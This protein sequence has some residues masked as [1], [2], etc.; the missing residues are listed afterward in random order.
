M[1]STEKQ[2]LKII[3]QNQGKASVFK[4]AKEIKFSTDYC[5]LI[6]RSLIRNKIIKFSEGLYRVTGLGRKRLEELGMME[7]E[8]RRDGITLS[9]QKEVEIPTI[10]ELSVPNPE[11]IAILEQ[12]GFRTLEDVATTSAARLMELIPLK[13]AAIII[14]EAREKLRKQGKEYLWEQEYYKEPSNYD[15]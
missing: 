6:C 7:K 9:V 2:V 11:I 5:R 10:T 3:W 4:I 8:K 1:I 15:H 14:N 12:N 13:L